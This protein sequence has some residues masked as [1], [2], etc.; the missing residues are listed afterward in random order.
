MHLCNASRPAGKPTPPTLPPPDARCPREFYPGVTM[1][2]LSSGRQFILVGPSNPGANERFPVAFLYHPLG[3]SAQSFLNG[4]ILQKLVEANRFLAVLPVSQRSGLLPWP[5]A[6]PIRL[7]F[8]NDQGRM[9]EEAQFFDDMLMCIGGHINVN[10][11]CV[12]VGGISAGALWADQLAGLRSQYLSSLVSVSG[13]FI[14][15]YFEMAHKLP[16]M[17]IWGGLADSCAGLVSFDAASRNLES[18]LAQSNQFTVECIH[19]CGHAAPPV[20]TPNGNPFQPILDFFL[21]HPYWLDPGASPYR[22]AGSLPSSFPT[23]CGMGATRATPRVGM[24]LTPSAC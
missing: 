1:T 20:D 19:N 11:D 6:L 2:T 15:S 7:P 16:A 23:W 13:G 3:G 4:G 14:A 17:V 10:T 21:D 9:A 8:V 5:A 24:C 18:V 12:G 22:D